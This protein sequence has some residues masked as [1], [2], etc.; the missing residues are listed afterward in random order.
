MVN[1]SSYTFHMYLI[2]DVP[3]SIPLRIENMY[4]LHFLTTA[5]HLQ[6]CF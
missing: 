6:V 4:I 1:T 5:I 3:L 2:A